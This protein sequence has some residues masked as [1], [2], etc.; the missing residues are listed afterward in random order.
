MR[1]SNGGHALGTARSAAASVGWDGSLRDQSAVGNSAIEKR[2]TGKGVSADQPLPGEPTTTGHFIR[3]AQ[4]GQ[5]LG[6]TVTSG[7]P[8]MF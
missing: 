7:P 5:W 3:E 1:T 2:K 6:P 4:Q 8:K